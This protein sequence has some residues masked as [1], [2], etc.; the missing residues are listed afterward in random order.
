MLASQK[1]Q[2]RLSEIRTDLAKLVQLEKPSEDETRSM[3]DLTAEAETLETKFRAALVSEDD[4]RREADKGNRDKPASDWEKLVDQFEV[5]QVISGQALDGAT[6]EVVSELR[7]KEPGGRGTPVPWEA[8]EER[9]TTVAANIPDPIMT[10]P[11]LDRLFAQ[12]VASQGL[13]ARFISIPFGEREYPVVNSDVTATWASSETADL[14]DATAFTTTDRQLKPEHHLGTKIELSRTAQLQAGPGLES[15]VRRDMQNA[16]R[17]TMD[18]AVFQGGGTGEPMG[19]ISGATAYGVTSTAI[20]ATP[21]WALIRNQVVEFMKANAAMSPGDI[22]L[23]LRPEAYST[24][25]GALF[26][27]GSGITEWDRVM[28]NLSS[29]TLSTNALAAP[30]SGAN[31]STVGI[32]STSAGGVAPIFVGS[33]GS[34]QIIRDELTGS[35][36]GKLKIVIWA[37][38]D[39]TASRSEQLRI[40]TGI[41]AS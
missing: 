22:R 38:M 28:D 1:I 39:V 13:G 11:I 9:A 31:P 18:K 19:V 32:M 25:D 10:A 34:P 15:A 33:W 23:V 7:E 20:N 26:D 8:L 12:S 14:P 30:T 41:R 40:V 3:S 17:I 5:R 2:K 35:D 36:S 16:I 4:E 27:T 21:T 24:L 37:T 6:A 29:V